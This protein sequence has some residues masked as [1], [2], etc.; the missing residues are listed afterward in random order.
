LVLIGLFATRAVK[1]FAGPLVPSLVA[2]MPGTSFKPLSVESKPH[3]SAS[4]S[5]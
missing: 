2:A 5:T 3:S 1:T 4:R